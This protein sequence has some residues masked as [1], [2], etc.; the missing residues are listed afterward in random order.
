MNRIRVQLIATP[1]LPIHTSCSA[2][3]PGQGRGSLAAED[4]GGAVASTLGYRRDKLLVLGFL[5]FVFIPSNTIAAVNSLLKHLLSTSF[6]CG[7][8]W[9][10]SGKMS[11]PLLS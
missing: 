11:K 1:L 10:H 9:Y 4:A 5:L 7:K 8:L 6:Y 2:H 3:R